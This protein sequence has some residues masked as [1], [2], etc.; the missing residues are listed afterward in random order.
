MKRVEGSP[1]IKL[2]ELGDLQQIVENE[3][4]KDQ[5]SDEA[6][7][8]VEENRED[9]DKPDWISISCLLQINKG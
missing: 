9:V 7:S 4:E 3:T 5:C 1:A 8:R 6:G 2:N